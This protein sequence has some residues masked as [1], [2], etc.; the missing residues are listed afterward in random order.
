MTVDEALAWIDETT[1]EA[2]ATWEPPEAVEVIAAETL[3][4][5]AQV[6]RIEALMHK[7]R[8]PAMF[9]PEHVTC[10]AA[11]ADCIETALGAESCCGYPTP[12]EHFGDCP[13]HDPIGCNREPCVSRRAQEPTSGQ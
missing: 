12:G 10:G 2:Y 11:F 5:R 6:E 13:R 3:R 8:D 7:M 4:L 1:H 9:K